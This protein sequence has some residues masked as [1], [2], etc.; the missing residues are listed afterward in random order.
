[1]GD[2]LMRA[3]LSPCALFFIWLLGVACGASPSQDR[4]TEGSEGI[5]FPVQDPTEIRLEA[6]VKGT[7]VERGG[8]LYVSMDEPKGL[9]LPIWPDGYSYVVD[10]EGVIRVLD[11]QDEVVAEVGSPVYMGGGE[12]GTEDSPLPSDLKSRVE[13]C[14]GPYWV[15][16]DIE[17]S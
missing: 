13:P 7:L 3:L 17:T 4:P 9:V 10:D 11:D 5:T 6:E 2:E 12:F 16:G 1:M 15:V 8:C 14:E